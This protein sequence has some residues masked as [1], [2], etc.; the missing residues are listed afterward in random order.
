MKVFIAILKSEHGK[1]IILNSW[2]GVEIAEAV[3]DAKRNEITD[4]FTCI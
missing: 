4:P 1:T 2:R 3:A